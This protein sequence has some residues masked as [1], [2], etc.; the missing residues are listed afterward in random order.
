MYCLSNQTHSWYVQN[1][2][3]IRNR[4]WIIKMLLNME[5]KFA[6]RIVSEM[7]LRKLST[8]VIQ[9]SYW[10]EKGKSIH[11]HNLNDLNLFVGTLHLP[12]KGTCAKS[13][14]MAWVS[15]STYRLVWEAITYPC[16]WYASLLSPRTPLCTNLPQQSVHKPVDIFLIS[17]NSGFH[18]IGSFET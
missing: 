5:F 10:H 3:F 16:H 8:Y 7:T 17:A 12:Y 13:V 9:M 15:N 11:G 6:W 18:R 4:N 14:W 1:I 2:F